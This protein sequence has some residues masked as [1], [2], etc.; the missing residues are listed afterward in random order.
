[1]QLWHYKSAQVKKIWIDKE[2]KK[3]KKD[4]RFILSKLIYC[5]SM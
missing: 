5:V 1:M 2:K 4:K 3:P